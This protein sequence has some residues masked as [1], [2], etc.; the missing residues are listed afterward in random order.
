MLEVSV[1]LD[2][3]ER[4][5]EKSALTSVYI[6]I[7]ARARICVS[8][9]TGGEKKNDDGRAPL[10]LFPVRTRETRPRFAA[11]LVKSLAKS[12][13]EEKERR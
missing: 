8:G 4:R 9:E 1:E 7:R 2:K 6:Y 12:E 3:R 10:F 13:G 11:R 5:E